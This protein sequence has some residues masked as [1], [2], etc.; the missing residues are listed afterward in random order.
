MQCLVHEGD[1]ATQKVL[2]SLL[3]RL[4]LPNPSPAQT[5]RALSVLFRTIRG[6]DLDTVLPMR[7]ENTPQDLDWLQWLRILP[8]YQS[9]LEP[10]RASLERALHTEHDPASFYAYA[11]VLWETCQPSAEAH[12][13]D[14]A[15]A[16]SATVAMDVVSSSSERDASCSDVL[17]QVTTYIAHSIL[18]RPDFVRERLVGNIDI[19]QTCCKHLSQ[20]IATVKASLSSSDMLE[21]MITANAAAE[22]AAVSD[23]PVDPS[24]T[25]IVDLAVL[26]LSRDPPGNSARD[27]MQDLADRLFCDPPFSWLTSAHIVG[28]ARARIASV[29]SMAIMNASLEVCRPYTAQYQCEPEIC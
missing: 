24:P 20:C 14:E 16:D 17:L 15:T 6:Q 19:F 27:V 28:L 7:L 29:S 10:I 2:C 4:S 21:P 23:F 9:C 13:S 26:L 12:R 25:A 22:A 3:D 11:C 1:V 8:N 5:K 18:W